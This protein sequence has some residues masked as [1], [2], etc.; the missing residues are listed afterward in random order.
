VG[1][2]DL[3]R[4]GLSVRKIVDKARAGTLDGARELR[5][6]SRRD[7]STG[8]LKRTAGRFDAERAITVVGST[9]TPASVN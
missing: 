8:C 2:D 3:R 6:N 5:R 1:R 9:K 7:A 4:S